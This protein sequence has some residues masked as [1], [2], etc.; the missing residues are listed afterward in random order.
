MPEPI[1]SSLQD[2]VEARTDR[3]VGIL[4]DLVRLPSENRAPAGTELAC[5]QYVAERLRRAGLD[6]VLYTPDDA[7]GIRAH[8]LYWPGRDY[9]NRPN[10]AARLPGRGGG[11][12][13]IL[14]GHIDTVP[15]GS[16]PWAHHPFDGEIEGNRLYGRGSND[17]KGGIATN[18]FVLDALR[19]LGISLAGD[20]IFETVVDE[21]FGGVNG[22]LAG[23]LMGF[24]AD[25]AVI[26]EPSF[27]RVCPAQR[28]GRTAHIRFRA[29]NEGILGGASTSVVEQLRVFIN[30]VPAFADGRRSGVRAHPLYVHLE[31]PVPAKVTR[32]STAPWGTS[33]PTNTPSECQIEFFW[34]AMPGETREEVDREFRMWL[35][36]VIDSAPAT[37]AA[38]P[39]VIFPIRWLPGS[40]IDPDLEIVREMRAS[41]AAITGSD[42]PVQGIEGPCD[43]FVFHEFGIPAVLWGARGGNTHNPDEY[44]E[45]D[46]LVKAAQ[47]LLE[48][49]CRWCGVAGR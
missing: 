16:Q 42:P 19:E 45:I 5:Q 39:E 4:R 10:I 25:A 47:V 43:M 18:L 31:N 23:R 40:A 12:S 44:V 27:L 14:S 35:N 30:A 48:F 32:I 38:R 46:S 36:S 2:H 28:G 33:E 49:V 7:P 8:P 21:E 20:L 13:L 9:T 34:E 24:T 15:A 41:A 1:A 22:T 29:A 3:I 11:R 6:P 37:F 26:S 17:M